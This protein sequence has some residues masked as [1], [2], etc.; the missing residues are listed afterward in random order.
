[1][2]QKVV[3]MNMRLTA[4]ATSKRKDVELQINS[5]PS[6]FINDQKVKKEKTTM[7]HVAALVINTQQIVAIALFCFDFLFTKFCY[8]GCENMS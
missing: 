7:C 2:A 3:S 6:V 1:M 4:G 8:F 5:K